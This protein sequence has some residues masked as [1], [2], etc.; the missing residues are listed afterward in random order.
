[1]EYFTE[2]APTYS[3]CMR[4][5]R[6]KYGDGAKVLMQRSVRVGGVLGL[7]AKDGVEMSGVVGAEPSRYG[8]DAPVHGRHPDLE[9][10]KRKI[11]A[12]LNKGDPTLQLVLSEVRGL[13]EKIEA[14][15]SRGAKSIR[16]WPGLPSSSR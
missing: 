11:L 12:N 16:P 5:I 8:V 14:S 3:E 13:K 4:K 1:M 7:F 9:E 6:A 15:A 2:Q 10:E